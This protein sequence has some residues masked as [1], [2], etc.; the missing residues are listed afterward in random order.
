M[1]RSLNP[2][3]FVFS[4]YR[5]EAD[6]GA[7]AKIPFDEIIIGLDLIDDIASRRLMFYD[8]KT[9]SCIEFYRK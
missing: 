1:K 8:S 2:V 9:K 6:E 5:P 7:H 3:E 4:D